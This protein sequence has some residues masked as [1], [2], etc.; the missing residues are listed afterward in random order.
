MTFPGGLERT[1]EEYKLLLEK[2]GF[3]LSSITPTSSAV[4]VIEGKPK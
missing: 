2:A 3:H 4:S 1:A